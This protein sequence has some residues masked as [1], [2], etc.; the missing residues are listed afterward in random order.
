MATPI[1]HKGPPALPIPDTPRDP[2]ALV[3]QRLL[4]LAGRRTASVFGA[5]VELVC[6][7]DRL[8]RGSVPNGERP[9]FLPDRASRILRE[10]EVWRAPGVAMTGNAF[11]FTDRQVILWATEQRREPSVEMLQAAYAIEDEVA[12]T[13]IVNSI[14]AAGSITR[15]HI[16]LLDANNQFFQTL[17][18]SRI[19][20]DQVQLDP[21]LLGPCELWRLDPPFPMTAVGVRGL[22]ADRALTMYH[23]VEGRSTASFNLV[24]SHLTSWLLPRSSVETPAPHFPQAL[25]GAEIW[26]RWCYSDLDAFERATETDLESALRL[27]GV[28]WS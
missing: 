9:G 21:E 27:A 25:G 10:E 7:P 23:L 5:S 15:S 12:G 16:H 20:P 26:G 13:T 1:C 14:G 19:S 17:P 6:L 28:P 22:P 4:N 18:Q 8:K 11:P 3:P 24:G 2:F